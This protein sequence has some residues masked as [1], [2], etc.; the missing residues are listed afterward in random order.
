QLGDRCE[1]HVGQRGDERI[2]ERLGVE[3]DEEASVVDRFGARVV[4]RTAT[5]AV[6]T[7]AWLSREVPAGGRTILDA[8]P[9]QMLQELVFRTSELSVEQASQ[10]EPCRRD[11]RAGLQDLEAAIPTRVRLQGCEHS[12]PIAVPSLIR[13]CQP[14]ELD[15]PDGGL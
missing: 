7:Q 2:G 12:V 3:A 11:A 14:I 1:Q 13:R 6:T 4:L 15:E 8:N 5:D 9:R 10:P